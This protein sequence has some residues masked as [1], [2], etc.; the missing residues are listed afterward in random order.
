MPK[1]TTDTKIDKQTKTNNPIE[2]ND[3]ELE[4]VAGAG[5]NAQTITSTF[6]LNLAP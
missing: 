4:K 3:A 1:E 2:L 6:K 5:S